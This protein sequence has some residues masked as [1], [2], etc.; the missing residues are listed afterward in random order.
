LLLL[1]GV[2]LIIAAI[3]TFWYELRPS[4]AAQESQPEQEHHDRPGHSHR[5]PRIAWLLVLPLLALIVV[6]PPALGSYAA[7]RTGTALQPP[8]G[9]ADLPAADP[10]QLTVVDYA[11]RAVY[12]H[13]HSLSG[14]QITITGFITVGDH[15]V[16]YLTRMVLS[17][18]AADAQPIKIG[19]AGKIPP[20]LRPDTWLQVTGGYIDKQIKD[21]INHGPIPFIDIGQARPVP[22]PHQQYES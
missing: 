7:D 10:L 17:C 21:P 15:G 19:L 12:D 2:V 6:V 20:G 9:F 16:P 4:R 18:C 5:E 8:V 11:T 3:A 14:R 1:T 13:G 22:A